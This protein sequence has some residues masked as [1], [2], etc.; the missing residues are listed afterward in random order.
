GE[1]EAVEAAEVDVTVQT[2]DGRTEVVQATK[3]GSD[4]AA[5]FRQTT[6]P[7][8]YRI[9]VKAKNGNEELG[10]AEARFLVPYQD[11]ELDRP[12]A[13]PSLMAQ[14]A[15]TTK[16]AGGA[17]LAP[18]ELPGLLKRLGGEAPEGKQ[19]GNAKVTYWDTWPFFLVFVGLIGT[20]W[21][22]RKRW[23]LV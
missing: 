11:L 1:G 9:K 16:T 19:G 3:T 12:A 18:E 15:E 5:T 23:G 20:E 4:W 2:P 22:L 8:D 13:E 21:F 14:L 7:G 17:A 10:T 6:K